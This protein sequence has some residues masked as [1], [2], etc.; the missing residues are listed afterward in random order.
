MVWK[1]CVILTF[2]HIP[3]VTFLHIFV[4]VKEYERVVR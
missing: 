3:S 2:A 4:A 1:S